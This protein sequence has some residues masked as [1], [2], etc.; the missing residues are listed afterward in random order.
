MPEYSVV[1]DPGRNP[2]DHPELVQGVQRETDSQ[3]SRGRTPMEFTCQV[4]TTRD[5]TGPEEVKKTHSRTS[6]KVPGRSTFDFSIN[7]VSTQNSGTAH[8]QNLSP[9]LLPKLRH[10][11][12]HTDPPAG[13]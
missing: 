11:K 13:V 6:T 12:I 8:L 5:M 1:R 3:G 9:H 4:A 10:V 2:A 7:S